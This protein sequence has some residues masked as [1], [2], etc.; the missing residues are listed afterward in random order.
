MPCPDVDVAAI[1]LKFMNAPWR[2]VPNVHTDTNPVEL[3]VAV[4][5]PYLSDFASCKPRICNLVVIV[6]R[7]LREKKTTL[8]LSKKNVSK[9]YTQLILNATP[10]YVPFRPC[11]FIL[12]TSFWM[13]RMK[14]P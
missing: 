10:S 12:L 9:S 8:S 13:L 7:N 14:L 4:S 6:A 11:A 1:H 5:V 3:S 2:H